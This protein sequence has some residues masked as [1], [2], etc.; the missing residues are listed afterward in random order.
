M[1]AN[2]DFLAAA[3][4][5]DARLGHQVVYLEGE[6]QW[7]FYD[8][9]PQLYKPTSAEKLGNLLRG[10][11]IRCAEELPEN[12]HKLNLFQ[13]FRSDKTIRSIVHRAKSI[14]AAD[15]TFFSPESKHARLKGVEVH[16][17]VARIGTVH[18]CVILQA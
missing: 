3:L 13:E 18:R 17:R 9:R 12:V 14:L 2:I 4:G 6:M 5:G 10:L 7:Y 11:L 16:E 15:H 8:G 1:S